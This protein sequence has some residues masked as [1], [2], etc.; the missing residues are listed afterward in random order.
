MIKSEKIRIQESV[1][2]AIDFCNPAPNDGIHPFK[3]DSFE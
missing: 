1:P 2:Y 3:L